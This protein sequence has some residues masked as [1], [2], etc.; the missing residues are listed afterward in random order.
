MQELLE[1]SGTVEKITFQN[2][3]SG[4]TVLLLNTADEL[5]TAVGTMPQVSP[6]EALRLTGKWDMHAS[7]GRQFKVSGFE[8]FAPTGAG[9]I[10]AYLSSGVI[11]GIGPATALLIVE[12]FGEQAL[13]VIEEDPHRLAGIKGISLP[14]AKKISEEFQK[15]SNIRNILARLAEY[16][17]KTEQ[18]LRIYQAYGANTMAVL[19][20]NP[21]CLCNEEIGL[22]F[23]QADAMANRMSGINPAYRNTAGLLHLLRHNL[24]NGHTCL[25]HAKLIEVA[26]QWLDISADEAEMM[27]DLL[28]EQ[29]QAVSAVIAGKPFIFLPQFYE[30]ERYAADRLKVM[31]T[32][33]P[34]PVPGPEIQIKVIEQVN[35]IVYDEVQKQAII[36]ALQSG[37]LILTGGPGT[38]KTTTLN[39]IISILENAGMTVL[40][41][42]PTGRAAK[43]MSE[44]C[45]HEAKTIH[46]LL[47]VEWVEGER[48]VFGRNEQNLLDCDAIIIDEVSMVD[49]TLFDA[50]LRALPLGCRMILVGDADQLPSVGAGNVLHDL[51]GSGLIPTVRLSKIF[52]QALQSHIV[53]NAHKIVAGEQPELGIKDNDF[54][55]LPLDTEQKTAATVADLI[56][57]RLPG[58]YGYDPLRDIQVLCPS[59]KRETGTANLN[60]VLQEHLNPPGKQKRE[61]NR[62]GF[63][64][65]EGDKVMQVKNN[66]DV[67]WTADDGPSGSGVF[68]GDIGIL[69]AIDPAA[70]TLTVRFDDRT[71]V[72]TREEAESLELAYSVTVHKSQG[73]EFECVVVPV[74]NVLPQLCYRNLLYT[75]V[76]RAKKLLILLGR[77]QAVMAMVQNNRKTLR[78]SGLKA[79]LLEK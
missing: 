63:V 25:P 67:L 60:R 20:E 72:Y 16:A 7:F 14:K 27:T 21:Y 64:L 65:R 23:E 30:S 58:S 53:T 18:A 33:P 52:R 2:A 12:T 4:F 48:S 8:C 28:C 75:A 66:Y 77:Q 38:G 62:I 26:A 1:I 73:N 78:Y 31:L 43:R 19:E 70:G 41:A 36:T 61:L 6:G 35:Q 32:C 10:L 3:D 79:F 50:L 13:R 59:K 56:C 24:Q 47:E 9:D 46:R 51:I 5:V 57:R 15:Q 40:L 39:A 45:R 55:F 17:V 37:M 68:N 74:I 42:A 71:A 49:V 22:T 44:L 69:T 34:P 76:T 11:R 29:K 54:F